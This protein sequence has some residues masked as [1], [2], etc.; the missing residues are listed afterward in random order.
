MVSTGIYTC[1][2]EGREICEVE[3]SANGGGRRLL[4]AVECQVLVL[5]APSPVP[6]LQEQLRVPRVQYLHR[7]C[8]ARKQW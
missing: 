4:N 5:P 8:T 3:D 6:F 2:G 1:G 7:P